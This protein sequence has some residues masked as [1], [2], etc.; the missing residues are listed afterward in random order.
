MR[1]MLVKRSLAIIILCSVIA[2]I[3]FLA[4]CF[5]QSDVSNYVFFAKSY[6][7]M[8]TER[9][10]RGAT[11]ARKIIPYILQR[12]IPLSLQPHP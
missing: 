2:V 11:A 7:K 9:R 10:L 8:E 1:K 12:H 3:V 4:V 6:E 5:G